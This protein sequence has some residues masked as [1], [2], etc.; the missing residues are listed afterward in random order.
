MCACEDVS[1][2]EDIVCVHVLT[3]YVHVRTCVHVRTECVHVRM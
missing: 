2:C 3:E 1:A